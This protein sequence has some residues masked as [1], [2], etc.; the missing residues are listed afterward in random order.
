MLA[1]TLAHD[2]TTSATANHNSPQGISS[3]G[4]YEQQLALIGEILAHKVCL[5]FTQTLHPKDGL[6]GGGDS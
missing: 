1:Y 3:N 2:A 5:S 6:P 4:L